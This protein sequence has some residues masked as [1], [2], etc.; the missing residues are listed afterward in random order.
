MRASG[1]RAGAHADAVAAHARFS[2]QY[3]SL[4]RQAKEALAALGDRK[5]DD[6]DLGW[7]EAEELAEERKRW[8]ATAA[9]LQADWAERGARLARLEA[10]RSA[11]ATSSARSASV[12]TR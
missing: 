12:P 1:R 8:E 6:D 9:R 5:D 10:Q 3:E 4:L 11:L 7:E 2:S